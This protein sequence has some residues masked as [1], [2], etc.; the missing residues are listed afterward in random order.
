[1]ILISEIRPN[2]SGL[3]DGNRDGGGGARARIYGAEP[4]EHT[5]RGRD[6]SSI[7]RAVSPSSFVLVPFAFLIVIAVCCV[8]FRNQYLDRFLT[9]HLPPVWS[10]NVFR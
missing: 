6:N 7:W 4:L 3:G 2:G 9:R 1:M 8:G 5:G 10:E